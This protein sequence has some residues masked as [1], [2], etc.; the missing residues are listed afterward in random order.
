M[1]EEV[2]RAPRW[3]KGWHFQDWPHRC[4]ESSLHTSM[5]CRRAAGPEVSVLELLADSIDLGSPTH[6]LCAQ[7]V[8]EGCTCAGEAGSVPPSQAD[9]S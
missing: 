7:A 2:L 5:G 4:S 6:D 3:Q 8:Q 9:L 1:E